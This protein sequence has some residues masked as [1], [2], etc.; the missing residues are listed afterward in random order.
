MHD[1]TKAQPKPIRIRYG[2]KGPMPGMASIAV[3]RSM[4]GFL[5]RFLS[6]T[7]RIF[8]FPICAGWADAT[9]LWRGVRQRHPP[10]GWRPYLAI[11]GVKWRQ[12][13]SPRTGAASLAHED[14]IVMGSGA[15]VGS[16][17]TGSAAASAAV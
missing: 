8:A 12:F 15:V 2:R 13:A 16:G 4:S 1:A 9:H 7:R 5:V 14:S 11:T 17:T 10:R 3:M 6:R